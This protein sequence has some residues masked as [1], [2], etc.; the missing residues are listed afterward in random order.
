MIAAKATK[1]WKRVAIELSP[2]ALALID[3]LLATGLHGLTRSEVCE[4]FILE[5]L[6]EQVPP[7]IIEPAGPITPRAARDAIESEAIA[8][9]DH[10]RFEYCPAVWK[11]MPNLGCT[12]PVHKAGDHVVGQLGQI[13]ARW[14]MRKRK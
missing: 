3:Q 5:K 2:Q 14:P 4:R 12:R 10:E 9:T 11:D 8:P 1:K 6:R 13:V 7:E